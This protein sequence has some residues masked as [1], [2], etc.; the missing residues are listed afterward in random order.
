MKL[1]LAAP[2]VA[3]VGEGEA[4]RKREDGGL[5]FWA[6]VNFE[7]EA[8]PLLKRRDRRERHVSVG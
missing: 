4:D 8:V 6:M 3:V 1:P 5:V 7:G 2:A